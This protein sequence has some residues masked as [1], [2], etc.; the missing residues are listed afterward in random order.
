VPERHLKRPR[1]SSWRN[2][3]TYRF[4]ADPTAR[5][6]TVTDF[7]I[8]LEP[9]GSLGVFMEWRSLALGLLTPFDYYGHLEEP[10]RV[11]LDAQGHPRRLSGG[12]RPVG[13]STR[14]YIDLEQGYVFSAWADDRF[15]YVEYGDEEPEPTIRTWYRIPVSQ[16]DDA[17]TDMLGRLPIM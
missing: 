11:F 12:W 9:R 3:P 14:P 16:F 7:V 17:W 6:T 4:G 8:A 15:V 13:T 2:G 5:P 10:D 1:E